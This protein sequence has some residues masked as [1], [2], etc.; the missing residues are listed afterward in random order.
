ML[1]CT[2]HWNKN[3][4]TANTT[5]IQ[6]FNKLA[7]DKA[8]KRKKINNNWNKKTVSIQAYMINLYL[9]ITI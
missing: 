3:R 6:R 5:F 1:F 2:F 8:I 7:N 9:L 4:M